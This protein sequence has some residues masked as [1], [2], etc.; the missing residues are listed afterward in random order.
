MVTVMRH[1]LSLSGDVYTGV[2]PSFIANLHYAWILYLGDMMMRCET[3]PDCDSDV[4]T[5]GY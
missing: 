2:L 3:N 1:Q 4:F 5:I